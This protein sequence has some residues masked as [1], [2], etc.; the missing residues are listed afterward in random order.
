MDK[1]EGDRETPLQL[2]VS[3]LSRHRGEFRATVL[4]TAAYVLHAAD[5]E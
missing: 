2:L 3:V 1:E 4:N 5:S